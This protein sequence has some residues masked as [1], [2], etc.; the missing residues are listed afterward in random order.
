LSDS[1]GVGDNFVLAAGW[2][3]KAVVG[4]YSGRLLIFGDQLAPSIFPQAA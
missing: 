3:N 2:L 4:F 1:K